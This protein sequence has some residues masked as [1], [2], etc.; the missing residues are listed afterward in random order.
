M[1]KALGL[2]SEINKSPAFARGIVALG[3]GGYELFAAK[4]LSAVVAATP[5]IGLRLRR[6]QPR[7]EVVANYP[8]LS[9]ADGKI[10]R[11]KERED[12]V[13]LRPPDELLLGSLRRPFSRS[14]MWP[15]PR[16]LR[17]RGSSIVGY[18]ARP[19]GG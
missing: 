7:T 8:L 3:I 19:C 4:R 6:V 1:I 16:R 5:A 13:C 2:R 18:V 17:A 12:A 10:P 11:W 14:A 15:S 9:E